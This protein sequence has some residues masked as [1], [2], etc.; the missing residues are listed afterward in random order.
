MSA[1][2]APKFHTDIYNRQE[3][4]AR[5]TTWLHDGVPTLGWAGD[6]DLRLVFAEGIEQ[7]WE[8]WMHAPR[9]N[10]PD[11]HHPV[12]SAPTGAELNDQLVYMLIQR[13]VANDTHR[14]GNSAEDQLERVI[15]END[16]KDAEHTR[17]ASEALHDPLAKFYFEAG[18]TLGVTKTFFPT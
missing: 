12:F 18:K 10:D 3:I 16:R 4:A 13:L 17:T 1:A 2:P 8:L 5:Y 7:R 14:A 6:P 9:R 11:Y 15:A